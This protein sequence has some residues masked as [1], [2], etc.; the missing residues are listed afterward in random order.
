M[1]SR[2]GWNACGPSGGLIEGQARFRCALR[3]GGRPARLYRFTDGLQSRVLNVPRFVGI[4]PGADRVSVV[5]MSSD[6]RLLIAASHQRLHVYAGPG[7]SGFRALGQT[8]SARSV[9]PLGRYSA[10]EGGDW[11][12]AGG[13][14]LLLLS[15]NRSVLEVD[16]ASRFAG[17]GPERPGPRVDRKVPGR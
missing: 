15:E 1:S 9:R 2:H 12:P 10:V 8:S 3:T 6:R 16:L 5:R 17:G 13:C 11:F 7:P 14:R 4:L